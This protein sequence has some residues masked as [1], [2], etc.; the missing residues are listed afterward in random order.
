MR[1]IVN[2]SRSTSQHTSKMYAI[3]VSCYVVRISRGELSDRT[4]EVHGRLRADILGGRCPGAAAQVRELRAVTPPTSAQPGRPSPAGREGLVAVTPN[5][6][7][8]GA[9]SYQDLATS[10]RRIEIE[11][12]LVR[13]SVQDGDMTWRCGWWPRITSSNAPR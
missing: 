9:L 11:T 2:L 1:S 7:T 13:L 8:G 12:R 4:D 5:Q 3:V 10:R 6:A